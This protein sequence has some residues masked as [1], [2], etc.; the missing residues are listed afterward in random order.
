MLGG[1]L[2]AWREY[3]DQ[4]FRTPDQVPEST[5]L[6]F[7]GMLEKLP[8]KKNERTVES[9]DARH[10]LIREPIMR[11]V[12]EIPL[13]GLPKR[14]G[15]RRSRSIFKINAGGGKSFGIVSV[16]PGEGKT[17]TAKNT[18]SLIALR[19]ARVLTYRCGLS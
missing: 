19:G 16:M 7:I 6:H 9:P 12:L 3:N 8:S 4:G 13:S 2:A 1:G 18:A 10:V 15:Q 5:G 11:H 14:C 17:T